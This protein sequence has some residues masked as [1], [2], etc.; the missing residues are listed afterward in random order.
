MSTLAIGFVCFIA[1]IGV[2]GALCLELVAAIV[3]RANR[4]CDETMAAVRGLYG[5][6]S[7]KGIIRC[8]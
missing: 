7:A 5:R 6:L 1:G 2:G 3:K 8:E 4:T